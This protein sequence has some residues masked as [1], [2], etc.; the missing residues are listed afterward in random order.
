MI[1]TAFGELGGIAHQV[2]DDLAQ[3]QSVAQDRLRHVVVDLGPQFEPGAH[4]LRQDEP[5]A[6]CS[7]VAKIDA[8]LHQRRIAGLDLRQIE[9]VVEQ[10]HHRRARFGDHVQ[11]LL[12]VGARM[13]GEQQVGKAKHAIHRRS[14]F[15]AHIGKEGR[16]R[17]RCDLGMAAGGLEFEFELLAV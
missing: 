1:V 2:E 5:R 10:A 15:V 3:P 8:F 16:F 4:R 13:F 12:L 9:D 6:A 11:F 17:L 7:D 14:D